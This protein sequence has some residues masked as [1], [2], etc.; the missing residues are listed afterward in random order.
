MSGWTS[1]RGVSYDPTSRWTSTRGISYDPISGWTS[2]RCSP[3]HAIVQGDSGSWSFPRVNVQLD[4]GSW[5]LPRVNV[6]VDIGMCETPRVG[7]RLD[8]GAW[9][10]R[11]AR[12]GPRRCPCGRGAL[13]F[14]N[15]DDGIL[16]ESDS[17]RPRRPR[18]RDTGPGQVRGFTRGNRS[19]LVRGALTLVNA[20]APSAGLGGRRVGQS[21]TRGRSTRKPDGAV[22][23]EPPVGAR[24]DGSAPGANLAR[25]RTPSPIA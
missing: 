8:G 17:D 4:S 22:R 23:A 21:S 10:A 16:A 5:R 6:Q 24:D 19:G 9:G 15:V 20:R 3:K 7:C 18:V 11:R 1:G 12:G 2:T 14:V 25:R 13:T